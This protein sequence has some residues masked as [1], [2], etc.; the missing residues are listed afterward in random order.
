M[1][2]EVTIL[3]K[4]AEPGWNDYIQRNT[5]STFFH[6][7]AWRDLTVRTYP[8]EPVYLTA[9]EGGQVTGI[10]PL[11]I[12]RNGFFSKKL[13]SLPYAVL[14]GVCADSGESAAAL[15]A[16]AK[17]ITR[18]KNLDFL[19]LKQNFRLD[20][21]FV[22]NKDYVTF[23]LRLENDPDIHWRSFYNEMRRCVRRGRE[24]G[25]TLSYSTDIGLF[26]RLIARAHRD[27]GTPVNSKAWI[28]GLVTTFPG[29]HRILTA[30]DGGR[31]IAVMLVREYRDT[32]DAVFGYVLRE[33]RNV[34]P[35]Y[36]MYWHLI[37]EACGRGLKIFNFGRSIRESGTFRF[38]QRWGA[39]PQQLYYH[40]L[41]NRKSPLDLSQKSGERNRIA[42]I[43]T[44]LPL[45]IANTAGPLIR[46]YYS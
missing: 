46:K 18:E 40:Y 36:V 14:G 5:S 16:R 39:E 9:K 41:P 45:G 30:V 17:I 21:D 37:Q 7:L 13:A 19:E 2:I 26:Y 23:L 8:C 35:L 12:A 31:V 42:K 34:Y 15:T 38:K 43:W 25:Y 4:T 24:A 44:R 32:M 33:Y 27:L 28:E 10:L 3:K 22:V 11:M 20:D 29:Q 6:Q 1:S